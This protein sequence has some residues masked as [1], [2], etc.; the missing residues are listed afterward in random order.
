MRPVEAWVIQAAS[1]AS[2]A[3]AC[4]VTHDLLGALYQLD[5]GTRLEAFSALEPRILGL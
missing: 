1:S 5:L 4:P 2:S 3:P